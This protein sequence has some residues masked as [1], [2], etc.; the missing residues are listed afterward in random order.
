[1]HALGSGGDGPQVGHCSSTLPMDALF[2]FGTFLF[3]KCSFWKTKPCC[4]I[5]WWVQRFKAG[6]KSLGKGCVVR[7]GENLPSRWVSSRTQD[8]H[9]CQGLLPAPWPCKRLSP[10][11]DHQ[12]KTILQ[13]NNPLTAHYELLLGAFFFFGYS[14]RQQLKEACQDSAERASAE[15]FSSISTY[16]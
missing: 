10:L 11:S 9:G 14:F 12:I 8:T 1:M 4:T 2:Q 3:Q 15:R 5:W 16:W 13:N 6:N 7:R